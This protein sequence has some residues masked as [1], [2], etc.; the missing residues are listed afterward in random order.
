[1]AKMN[2]IAL[3]RLVGKKLSK[4]DTK[5]I[6]G[7]DGATIECSSYGYGKCYDQIDGYCEATGN[8]NDWCY[9]W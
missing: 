5:L 1:M 9:A 3:N 8:P 6:V 7:G 2:E 4:Q